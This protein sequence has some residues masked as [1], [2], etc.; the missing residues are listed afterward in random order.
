[1]KANYWFN[2]SQEAQKKLKT[3]ELDLMRA[4]NE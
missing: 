4:Y 3:I 1:M 2:K